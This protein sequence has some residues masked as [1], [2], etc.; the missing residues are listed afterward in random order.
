MLRCMWDL[1]RPGIE[2]VS[3]ALASGFLTTGPSGFSYGTQQGPEV[4][5]KASQRMKGVRGLLHIYSQHRADAVLLSSLNIGIL[6]C[7]L[8]KH[9]VALFCHNISILVHTLDNVN[10]LALFP[11]MFH[12]QGQYNMFCI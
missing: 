12:G 9:S 2:L 10:Y 3:P 5:L 4:S 7:N 8:K 6:R 11:L 1:L